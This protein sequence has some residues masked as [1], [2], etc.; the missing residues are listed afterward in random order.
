[1]GRHLT[2]IARISFCERFEFF[3]SAGCDNEV[4]TLCRKALCHLCAKTGGSTGNNYY[5]VFQI[6][7]FLIIL[8]G[9]LKKG[10]Y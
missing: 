6:K 8:C 9:L 7:L 5:T 1:M 10:Y 4:S 2:P 3:D